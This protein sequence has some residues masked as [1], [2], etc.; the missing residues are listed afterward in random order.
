MKFLNLIKW[1]LLIVLGT[2]CVDIEGPSREA[3]GPSDILAQIKIKSEAIMIAKGDSHKI[4]FDIIAM[5]E[6][7][8]PYDASKIKWTTLEAQTVTVT[9]DGVIYGRE[10]SMSPI[11]II[12]HYEHKYVTRLDTVSVYVTDGKIDANEIRLISLDS[13]RIGGNPIDG[14]RPRLRVDLYKNGVLVKKGSLIPLQPDPPVTTTVDGTGG[15]DSEPVYRVNNDNLLIG[16]F[17]IRASLNMYGNVVSDSVSFT[18]LYGILVSPIIVIGNISENNPGPIPLLDTIPLRPYQLCSYQ[19]IV[20]MSTSAVDVVFSDST[21]SDS[22]C[23]PAPVGISGALGFPG[24]GEFVGGNVLNIPS[25]TVAIRRSRTNG[26]VSY[27][28][29][30][31][32]SKVTIP[33]FIGHMKQVDV[34]D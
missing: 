3:L 14:G 12:V 34:D 19:F 16:K 7:A 5:N 30:N 6:D 2:A 28:V 20:N 13:N 26:V 21:E 29:R 9:N 4:D 23:D 27:T 22:G 15:P 1:S 33:W 18:G 32:Q 25:G 10:V 24:Y 11:K 8:I 31:S 17:W